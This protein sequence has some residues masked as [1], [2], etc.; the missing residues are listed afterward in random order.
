MRRELVAYGEHW[1][2]PQGARVVRP[3]DLHVTLQFL[4][5][6]AS[7]RLPD[8]DAALK[9]VRSVNVPVEMGQ[10]EV[11]PGGIAIVHVL[12]NGSL[13]ELHR[14][15]GTQLQQLGIA[16]DSRLYWPHITLAR[17]ARGA[18]PPA[19]GLR[20]AHDCD[21]MV[22]AESLAAPTPHYEHLRVYPFA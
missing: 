22:L 16:L 9:A 20:L 1:G 4:G 15:I 18:T 19:Q 3:Q 17:N 5:D 21:A 6:I 10:P 14:L 12:P 13:T 11:W 7:E 2:W 8:L